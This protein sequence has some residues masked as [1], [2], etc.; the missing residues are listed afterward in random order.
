MIYIE[1]KPVTIIKYQNY[2]HHIEWKFLIV[3]TLADIYMCYIYL[4]YI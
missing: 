2:Y 1:R 4:Y 3:C